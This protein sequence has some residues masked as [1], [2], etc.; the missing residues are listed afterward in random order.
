[1]AE[2]SPRSCGSYVVERIRTGLNLSSELSRFFDEL[3]ARKAV[4]KELG[5]GPRNALLDRFVEQEMEFAREST[6]ESPPVHP[7]LIDEANA[8]FRDLVHAR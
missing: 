2:D 7:A 1:M 3:I 5:S 4:T 8:L 6:G